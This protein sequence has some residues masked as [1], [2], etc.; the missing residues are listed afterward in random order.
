MVSNEHLWSA[1]LNSYFFVHPRGVNLSLSKI[2]AC[3][4]AKI[5]CNLALSAGCLSHLFCVIT[6]LNDLYKEALIPS[7]GSNTIL[8]AYLIKVAGTLGLS[9]IVRNNLKLLLGLFNLWIFFSNSLNQFG[10]RCT[11]FNKTQFPDLLAI[12]TLYS[13]YYKLY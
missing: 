11:F 9:S 10:A 8:K 12:S 3:S 2:T 6:C 1:S 7:G 13:A 4:Q 5:K